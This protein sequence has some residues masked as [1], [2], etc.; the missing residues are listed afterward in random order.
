MINSNIDWYL[1]TDGN[2]GGKYDLR[3]AVTRELARG[4]ALDTTFTPFG[5]P[6]YP[7]GGWGTPASPYPWVL[8]RFVVNGAGQVLVDT[9]P[10]HSAALRD[11]VNGNDLF[12]NGPFA[13]AANGGSRP[14]LFA[15]H[16]LEWYYGDD[17]DYLDETAFAPGTPNALLTV[18]LNPGEVIHRP[19]PVILAMMRDVGWT[20]GARV[21]AV[22]DFDGDRKSDLAIFRP[23]T[24]DWHYR[25]SSIGVGAQRTWGGAGDVPLDGDFNGDGGAD[26]AVFRPSTGAWHIA[27]LP[28]VTWGGGSDIPVPADYNGDRVTDVAVFR[29]S[30]GTWY[31]R[32]IGNVVWGGGGDVPVPGDYT[33]DGVAEVAVFRPSTGAWYIPGLPAT[34]WGGS[35]DIPVPADYDGDGALNVAVF[36]PATGTWYVPGAPAIVWGVGTDIP[37]PGDYDGNG[38]ADIAVFRPSTGTWYARGVVAMVWGGNG[39]V[40][41]AR[42]P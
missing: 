32:G 37:V 22:A 21:R 29:P 31:I 3:T 19:G 11:Q 36:R 9:F 18:R 39:D 33:G 26:V 24:G 38:V 41:I 10:N 7:A 40:P 4:L 35:G 16:Y 6:G 15:R 23:S 42:R 8:D 28:S 27:G 25:L 12:F 2:T 13:R 20:V 1:G 17:N 5:Q 34:V 30:N 14:K